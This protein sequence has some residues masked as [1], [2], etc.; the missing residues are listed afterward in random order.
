MGLSGNQKTGPSSFGVPMFVRPGFRVA[1]IKVFEFAL[2]ITQQIITSLSISRQ[3][4]KRLNL[5]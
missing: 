1:T 2:K 3:I 5:T 4:I